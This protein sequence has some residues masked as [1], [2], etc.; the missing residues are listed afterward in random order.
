MSDDEIGEAATEENAASIVT[1]QEFASV[2]LNALLSD[3]QS[4]D[5]HAVKDRLFNCANAADEEGE[6]SKS[7]VCRLLAQILSIAIRIDSP[8]NPFGPML[9]MDGRRSLIPDNLGNYILDVE[10]RDSQCVTDR[11][12]KLRSL[13]RC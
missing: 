13:G 3:L 8:S 7:R 9:I 1:A 4:A 10:S 5:D 6:I 11:P 12:A 2:D